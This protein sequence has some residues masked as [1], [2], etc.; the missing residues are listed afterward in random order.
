M[1]SNDTIL[2][3]VG[4]AGPVS[5]LPLVLW[6]YILF[7]GN[8]TRTGASGMIAG[9]VVVIIWLYGSNLWQQSMRYSVSLDS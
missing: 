7:I 3:L 5:V 9:A 1:V 8:L 6:C 4:N 2:N